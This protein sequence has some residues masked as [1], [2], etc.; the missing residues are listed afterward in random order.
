MWFSLLLEFAEN[1]L[2]SQDFFDAKISIMFVDMRSEWISC[3]TD[4]EKGILKPH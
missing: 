3:F 4:L 1:V 2:L